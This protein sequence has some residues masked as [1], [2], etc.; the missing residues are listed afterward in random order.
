V[1]KLNWSELL[2]TISVRLKNSKNHFLKVGVNKTSPKSCEVKYLYTSSRPIPQ[3]QLYRLA[4]N[5]KNSHR[6]FEILKKHFH[7]IF[8]QFPKARH[9]FIHHSTRQIPFRG[10]TILYWEKVLLFFS[11]ATG[12]SFIASQFKLPFH[13]LSLSRVLEKIFFHS[14]VYKQPSKNVNRNSDSFF[15][16]PS[17]SPPVQLLFSHWTSET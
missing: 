7:Q 4:S 8:D 3:F 1:E 5:T 17:F 6:I 11:I 12:H 14:R 2:L 13:T 16:L 10:N 15:S 9:Q